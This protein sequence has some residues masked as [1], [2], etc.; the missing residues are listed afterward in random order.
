MMHRL[1]VFLGLVVFALLAPV[2][3]PA[4]AATFKLN[5]GET[6]EGEPKYFQPQGL[7]LKKADGTDLPRVAWTN[8]TQEALKELAANPNAKKYV[9][10]LIEAEEAELAEREKKAIIEIKPKIP[11]RL[12]RPDP[13]AGFGALFSSTVTLLGFILIYVG[14]VYAGYEMGLYRNYHP[15]LTAGVAAIAP[16]V[17][18]IIFL[19]I[20]TRI[21][22]SQ[23][24]LAAESM[25][26]HMA[27]QQAAE[28]EAAPQFTPEELAAQQA[29]AEAAAAAAALAEANKVITY[30]RGQFTFNRRFF[31]SKLAGFLRLVPG[32]AEKNKIIYIKSSRGEHIGARLTKIEPN[33]LYLQ[34]NKSGATSDVMIP[35][36]EIF[37]VQ[38]R[39][40]GA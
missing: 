27:A 20:P 12:D 3:F 6:V 7:T 13:A 19:C 14:N 9:Q 38:I 25:A 21:K 36:N 11:E 10:P 16:I 26:A 35:F 22:K 34:I 40:A 1:A 29:A 23:D 31:E 4:G 33:E 5:T 37:E 8:F 32:E 28:V 24:Q 17:G 18:P 39:P 30:A 2:G 15:A